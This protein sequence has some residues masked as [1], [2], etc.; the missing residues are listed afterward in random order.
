MFIRTGIIIDVWS[1]KYGYIKQIFK[2]NTIIEKSLRLYYQ[3]EFCIEISTTM[4]CERT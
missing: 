3:K 2:F 4:M 1:G